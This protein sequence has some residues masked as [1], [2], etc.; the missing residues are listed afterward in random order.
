[1]A[2]DL[3]S[4]GDGIECGNGNRKGVAI[5]VVKFRNKIKMNLI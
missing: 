1:M 3:Q 2:S 5:A 4:S